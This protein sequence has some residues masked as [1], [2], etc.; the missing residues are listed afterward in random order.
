MSDAVFVVFDVLAVAVQSSMKEAVQVLATKL[1][2]LIA[3]AVTVGRI[4]RAAA[5]PKIPKAPMRA[6]VISAKM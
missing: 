6:M 1:S 2:A 3:P 4:S 5:S